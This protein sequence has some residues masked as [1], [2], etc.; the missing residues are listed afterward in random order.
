MAA[1]SFG[2]AGTG[3]AEADASI[4]VAY[5]AS[6]SA[7][8]ILILLVQAKDTVDNFDTPTD[9]T[10]FGASVSNTS[11][12]SKLFWKRATGSESGTLTVTRTAGAVHFG[13]RIYRYAGC[14]TTGNPYEAYTTGTD[15]SAT[16]ADPQDTTTT[17]ADRRICYFGAI[18]DDNQSP[19]EM[20]G[21]TATVAEEVA[22]FASGV[23]DDGTLCV[24]GI[25][26]EGGSGE[27][28]NPGS[29]STANTRNRI[30]FAL[31]LLP[32]AAA[33]AF[34]PRIVMH[35]G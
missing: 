10:A 9:W 23:G 2:S 14:Q 21:G 4:D 11:H 35:M 30:H 13:A 22:E 18:E 25:A 34:V 15:N 28:F 24:W 32:A 16:P 7:N 17:G 6:I 8:D 5:P 1:P 19:S 31:A 27:T 20:T 12:R 33:A 26:R 3:I 29:Y